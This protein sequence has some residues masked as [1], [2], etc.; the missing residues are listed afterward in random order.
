[1]THPRHYR[2]A[3]RCDAADDDRP[4]QELGRRDF[5][6]LTPS[7]THNL[8]GGSCWYLPDQFLIARSLREDFEGQHAKQLQLCTYNTMSRWMA[9]VSTAPVSTRLLLFPPCTL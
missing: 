6:R 1:M 5:R 9:P 4:I 2:V 8:N 7:R 3:C